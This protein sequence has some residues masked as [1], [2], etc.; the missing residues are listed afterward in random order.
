MEEAYVLT[1][2]ATEVTIIH[3]RDSFKATPAMQE[4]V[5]ENSKIKIMWNTEVVKANGSVK[6]ESLELKNVLDNTISTIPFDGLFIAIGHKPTS[7]VFKGIVNMDDKGYLLNSEWHCGTNI[8]GVFVA[9]DV[10]DKDFKQA[11]VASGMGCI[12]AME[13]IKY[14]ESV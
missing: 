11:I 13:A 12:A 6:L 1:K 5:K 7:D 4:K 8:K 14:L 2:Y 3:R 10:V 9:G